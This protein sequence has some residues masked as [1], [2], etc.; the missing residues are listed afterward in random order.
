MA[1]GHGKAQRREPKERHRDR[2][3]RAS[4]LSFYA[5]DAWPLFHTLLI[6][7]WAY[8]HILEQWWSW[9]PHVVLSL[10]SSGSLI[11]VRLS[12]THTHTDAHTHTHT[13]A[14][15][16]TLQHVTAQTNSISDC[17][18]KCSWHWNVKMH[19]DNPINFYIFHCYHHFSLSHLASLQPSINDFQCNY[20]S[21]QLQPL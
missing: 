19:R 4:C 2:Q 15:A 1:V 5:N 21:N 14:H 20:G 8:M 9:M 12:V 7:Y 10:P 11:I 17:L 6:V 18:H 13:H 16:H 3:E